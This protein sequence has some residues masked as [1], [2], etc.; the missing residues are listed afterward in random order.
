MFKKTPDQKKNEMLKNFIKM[1]REDA[2]DV[3]AAM[4]FMLHGESKGNILGW[5]DQ[6]E[7]ARDYYRSLVSKSDE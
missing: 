5:D 7:M 4:V 1:S 2:I 6:G 3:A